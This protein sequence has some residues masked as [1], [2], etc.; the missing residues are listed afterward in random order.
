MKRRGP[1]VVWCW[2]GLAVAA[3]LGL[4]LS[5]ARELFSLTERL[6][7]ITLGI[8]LP[9]H[10][11]GLADTAWSWRITPLAAWW[12]IACGLT[13]CLLG[14]Q[15]EEP[16]APLP[17]GVLGGLMWAALLTV[18]FAD[19]LIVM[20]AGW[21]GQSVLIGFWLA[22]PARSTERVTAIRRSLVTACLGGHD[23]DHRGLAG[24]LSVADF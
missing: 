11:V 9:W 2:T 24:R 12:G 5:D 13:A 17:M 7:G 6:T 10:E 4:L 15:A 20:T 14:W 23:L 18:L 3:V 1:A 19:N 22:W 21:C 8:W 16:A